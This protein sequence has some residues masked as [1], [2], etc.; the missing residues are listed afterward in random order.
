[1]KK[2]KQMEKNGDEEG[3]KRN[4]WL[5]DWP[6][7][8]WIN[9]SSMKKNEING[10]NNVESVQIIKRVVREINETNKCEYEWIEWLKQTR[11]WPDK[12]QH[13][14]INRI[15]GDKD[16]HEWAYTN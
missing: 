6:R 10:V 1:M 9:H 5:T 3:N 8:K 4:K 16:Q 7:N 12:A 14:G 11:R 15:N 2:W 13:Q